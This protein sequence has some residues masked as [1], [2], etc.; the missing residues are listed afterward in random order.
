MINRVLIRIKVLQTLYSFMLVEKQFTLESAPSSPTKEKRF[1]YS[2][3]QDMLVLMIK[4]ARNVER[5]NNEYPLTETKFISRLLIDDQIK[6]L[7]AK[8]SSE[9]FPLQGLVDA[10]SERIQ[11][12]G[13]YKTY[14]KDRDREGKAADET[15]WRD[16]F[17]LVITTAPE[18]LKVVE[19]RVNFTL[20]GVERMK[21]MINTTLENFLASQDNVAEVIRALE[22]GLDKSREL[23]FRLLRLP[24][25]LTDI[26]ER[27]LDDNRHK[28]LKNDEDLN[29]NLRFVENT[30][31]DAI[32]NNEMV[33]AYVKNQKLSWEQEDPAM[34][35]HLL[36][37]IRKSEVYQEYMAA[38]STDAHAD[39]ELWRNLYKKVILENRYFLDALEEKS[40]F[41]NDDLEIISTFAMKTLR[42]M[43]EENT[44]HAVL[45]KFKD[46]EDAHFGENLIKA[47]YRNKETYRGYIDDAVVGCN[48]DAE[49]LAFMDVVVLQTAIAEILNFPKIPLT[50]SINEYIEL[51][52]SYSSAKSGAFVNGLLG[53]I[54]SRLQKDNLL[55]KK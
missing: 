14:L 52:K 26:Q 53:S 8:Y 12:S 55:L 19:H 29:P 16:L 17:N 42:R 2:L 36:D 1:A 34:M 45:D 13:V 21:E 31:V 33:N 3:Y 28:F 4:L 39:G 44:T 5:R 30:V 10:V 43:E 22:T 18:F 32:R 11:E 47:V 9:P 25:E 27:I 6:S 24:V 50:V 46:E 20:R 51:A 49:R 38:P 23:Y 40:V 7:M 41:W 48:W 35:R 15:V 54:I 37:D